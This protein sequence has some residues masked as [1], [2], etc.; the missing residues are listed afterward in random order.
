MVGC[1]AAADTGRACCCTALM[2]LPIGCKEPDPTALAKMHHQYPSALPS[3][4]PSLA[5]C[6]ILRIISF[7]VTQLPAPNYHCRLGKDTAVREMPEH[8]WGHVV[9]D[10]GRQVRTL[11]GRGRACW[12]QACLLHLARDVGAAGLQ[13]AASQ[14]RAARRASA[15]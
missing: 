3:P 6:Q 12:E 7:T 10:V 4:A 8:W 2:L 5:A 13:A 9:V 15:G 14:A 11:H 1:G